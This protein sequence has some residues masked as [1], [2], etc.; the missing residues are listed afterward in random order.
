[1]KTFLTGSPGHWF[2]WTRLVRTRSGANCARVRGTLQV[3]CGRG[4]SQFG[5]DGRQML[6]QIVHVGVV[7]PQTEPDRSARTRKGHTHCRE[8]VRRIERTALAGR[9]ARR[10]DV[11]LIEQHQDRF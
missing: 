6:E 2:R 9:A 8:H 1:N 11:E 5:N 4:A 7:Y 10:T 3:L